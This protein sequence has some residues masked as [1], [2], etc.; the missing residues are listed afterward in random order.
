MQKNVKSEEYSLFLTVSL[1]FSMGK[2]TLPESERD[3]K[4]KTDKNRTFLP[5]YQ[6]NVYFMS[7]DVAV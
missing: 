5:L 3:A 1:K 4:Y 6:L 2:T 7:E